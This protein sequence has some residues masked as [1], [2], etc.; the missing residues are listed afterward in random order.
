MRAKKKLEKEAEQAR[1]LALKNKDPEAYLGNL[2][3]QRRLI[4]DRMQDRQNKKLEISKRGSKAAQRRMQV[5]A[6][7]GNEEKQDMGDKGDNFG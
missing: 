7:L 3:E 2:Y 4:I 6:E 5:L 1:I